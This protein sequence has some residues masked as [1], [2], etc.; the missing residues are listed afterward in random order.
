MTRKMRTKQ[1]HQTESARKIRLPKPILARGLE[2]NLIHCTLLV[3]KY[4]TNK[5]Y[6]NKVEK[7]PDII[8]P[9][10]KSLLI[11]SNSISGYY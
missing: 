10:D 8:E 4:N 3:D 7:S 11:M 2:L 1:K 9:I 5:T 6:E